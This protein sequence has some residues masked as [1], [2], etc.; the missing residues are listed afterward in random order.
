[1]FEEN[2]RLLEKGNPDLAALVKKQENRGFQLCKSRDND[3]NIIDERAFPPSYYHSGYSPAKET[4]KWIQGI[5]YKEFDVLFIYGLGL[6]YAFEEIEGFLQK[7]DKYLVFLEDEIGAIQVFLE[8]HRARKVLSHPKVL[9]QY[10]GT[11]E[12][13]A[14][15]IC[16]K[17][18]QYF[19]GLSFTC[20]ALPFYE[21]CKFNTFADLRKKFAHYGVLVGYGSR[22]LLLHGDTY[23][24]NFYKNW[25]SFKSVYET[26]GLVNKF[27]GVPAVICGAGPSLNKNLDQLKNLKEKALIFA[28]GSAVTLLSNKGLVPHIGGAVD[29]NDIQYDRML[30]QSAFELPVYFKM[31]LYHEALKV[32]HGPKLFLG[33]SKVYPVTNWMQ[34]KT[35][36][37]GGRGYKEGSNI[38]H[39]LIDLA[40][41]LGCY[42]II[43]VGLDLA[44]TQMQSYASGV[45]GAHET[46]LSK[47]ELT[48][49]KDINTNAFPRE[50]FYGGEV[51]TLWK[52][53][54]EARYSGTYSKEHPECNLINCTEG[55]L[56]I[57]GLPHMTLKEA[58]EK[59]LRLNYDLP[60]WI[61][62]EIQGAPCRKVRGP[63]IKELFLELENSFIKSIEIYAEINGL[64]ENLLQESKKRNLN[65]VNSLFKKVLEKERGLFKEV[66]FEQVLEPVGRVKAKIIQR[67]VD[68]VDRD[69]ER[70]ELEKSQ[71]RLE[72]LKE[73]NLFFQK[74]AELNLKHISEATCFVNK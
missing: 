11:S 2:L 52:W 66:A 39:L 17:M 30:E 59:F 62:Q 9:I 7:E 44:F 40:R 41:N 60:G 64:I 55:G 23:F 31:R 72:L 25:T 24:Q 3:E 34:E 20:S 35:G 71:E 33:N 12:K 14:D 61:H 5:D 74:T 53:V 45:V 37:S 10:L 54:E 48:E 67:K 69:L 58:E 13:E 49:K 42:P 46:Y 16:L 1:V 15:S 36:V 8:S 4:G 21:R 26:N 51:Y 63:L 6:A 18:V 50:S 27:K 70:N 28:G 56:G 43:L 19:V 47:D 32:L 29:P 68:L 73:K 38:I 22:E 65:K 57:R